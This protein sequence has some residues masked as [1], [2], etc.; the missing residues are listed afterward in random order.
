MNKDC[1]NVLNFETAMSQF[2]SMFPNLNIQMIESV[3]RKNDGNVAQTI[4]ELLEL[5]ATTENIFPSTS[6]SYVHQDKS[7][8][9]RIKENN[10]SM[11]QSSNKNEIKN[12]E[13]DHK[14][15]SNTDPC[16]DDEKIALLIQNREF[17]SYLRHDPNF[18]KAIIGQHQ[19]YAKNAQNYPLP[20][21]PQIPILISSSR[22]SRSPNSQ[23][24]SRKG[25]REWLNQQNREAPNTIKNEL[26]PAIPEGPLIEYVDTESRESGWVEIIKSKLIKKPPEGSEQLPESPLVN[27]SDE[28]MQKGIQGLISKGGHKLIERLARKFNK[29]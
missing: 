18:Q 24:F 25:R 19:A 22:S 15:Q 17:L 11:E 8:K 16:A 23:L 29:P 26:K 28:Q 6:S 5:S 13:D 21:G 14:N 4:E 27:F 3:L 9:E 2:S 7:N 20:A 1:D 10:G 12:K